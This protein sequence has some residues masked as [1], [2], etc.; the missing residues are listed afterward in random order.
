VF[1]KG[2]YVNLD[3]IRKDNY[4]YNIKTELGIIGSDFQKPYNFVKL[5]FTGHRGCGKSIELQRIRKELEKHYFVVP[6]HIEKDIIKISALES[7][8][9][10]QLFTLKLVEELI[11]KKIDFNLK[12]FQEI[13][14]IWFKETS[15]TAEVT[16][17]AEVKVGAEVEVKASIWVAAF[18]S[19]LQTIITAESKETEQIRNRIKNNINDI[20]NRFNVALTE[21]R[22]K[23]ED[24]GYADVLFVVD[25]TE[26]INY[27]LSKK[28]FVHDA[29][30]L[31]RIDAHFIF[32]SP[33][34]GLFD[35]NKGA[36][37]FSQLILPMVKLEPQ[38][39]SEFSKI[40]THRIEKDLFFESDLV[41]ECAIR[42][43]GGCVRQ[44]LQIVHNSL[45]AS[46]GNKISEHILSETLYEMGRRLYDQLNTHHREV[47][48]KGYNNNNNFV[49]GDNPVREMLFNLTLLA[50]NGNTKVNPIIEPFVRN[51]TDYLY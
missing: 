31:N 48:E 37:F 26:K 10:Y 18:K 5:L 49:R 24:D 32:S 19:F 23:L 45:V 21:L 40:I 20:I 28:I 3:S 44:L 47:L 17:K 51:D 39:I 11:N 42:K 25:G 38:N 16:K 43:S 15:F 6:I 4:L 50:Y 35:I 9:L 8:D 13:T 41:L 2:I 22:Y 36:D 33:V 34:F 12:V 27:E 7:E 46:R 29:S 30:L 1:E 14:D